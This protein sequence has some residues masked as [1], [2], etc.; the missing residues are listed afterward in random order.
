MPLFD[1]VTPAEIGGLAAANNLSDVASASTSL[2]NLGGAPLAN[3]ALTGNPTAPTQASSDNSTKLATTAF[4]TAVVAAAVQGLSIKP[5]VQEATAAALPSNVYSNGSSGVGATLTGVATGTLTVDGILVAL[6]DR[7]LVKNEVTGANNGLYTCTLAG[8]VGVAYV[9]TRA[10]DMNTA[11]QVPGAFAFVEQGTANAGAG[12][13]VASEGPFTVGTTAITWTQFSGAGEI[14]PGTGLSKSGNTL[15]LTT[16][17]LPLAGGTMSGAI[18]MGGNAI[19]GGATA[20][21]GDNTT[22][23]ATDAFVQAALAAVSVPNQS[24]YATWTWDINIQTYAALT[25]PLPGLA[26]GSLLLTRMLYLPAAMTLAGDLDAVWRNGGGAGSPTG[27]Y[28]GVYALTGGN[29][30]LQ[31]S[32]SSDLTA[33][34]YGALTVATGQT[35]WPAG[36]Y[37]IGYLAA[38]Q[39]SSGTPAS[40][41]AC[42][43]P[44]YSFGAAYLPGDPG[45]AIGN[46]PIAGACYYTGGSYTTLP[47][48]VALSNFSSKTYVR[49]HGA[50]R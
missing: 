36:W 39:A 31:G 7:V 9:L 41:L 33:H 6:N 1:P 8:A 32:G 48:S 3:A 5:S 30:V 38:T 24:G 21:A 15:S 26:S 23:I 13:T 44:S 2:A 40:P 28:I 46:A 50:L 25:L 16:P 42:P 17:A 47:A 43:N 14:T 35:A 37:A 4:V 45:T 18:A 27:T 29:A 22:Q 12:F 34:A 20:G 10:A 49:L 19:T 11:A